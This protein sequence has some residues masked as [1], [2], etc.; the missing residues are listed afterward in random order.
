LL[1]ETKY[2]SD[3][4]LNALFRFALIPLG[5]SVVNLIPFYKIE[6]GKYDTGIEVKYSLKFSL[7][8]P[9]LSAISST[10]ASK[11]FMKNLAK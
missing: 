11:P 10:I 1:Q 8:S 2:S 9:S 7:I 3:N 6:T 5:G 4:V